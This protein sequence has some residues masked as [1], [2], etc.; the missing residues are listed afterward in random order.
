[1]NP[2]LSAKMLVFIS[3]YLIDFNASRSAIAAGYRDKSSGRRLL[4]KATVKKEI[5]LRKANRI[6]KN[7]VTRERVI[8]ELERLAFFDSGKLFNPDGTLKKVPEMDMD[9]RSVIQG[10]KIT[11]RAGDESDEI[12]KDYKLTN[13]QGALDML[14]KH[15][16]LYDHVPEKSDKLKELM[17]KVRIKSRDMPIAETDIGDDDES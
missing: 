14:C 4:R 8:A 7:G 2:P 5:A 17:D 15:L 6:E 11:T 9:T 3:E 10:I 16:G 13:R 12:T 1:M